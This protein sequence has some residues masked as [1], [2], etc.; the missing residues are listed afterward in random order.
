MVTTLRPYNYQ[1]DL[2]LK[3]DSGAKARRQ[4]M[5]S[6]KQRDYATFSIQECE[7]AQLPSSDQTHFRSTQNGDGLTSEE[8]TG[9]NAENIFRKQMASVSLSNASALHEELE[10]ILRHNAEWVDDQANRQ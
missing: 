5:P 1:I 6:V 4:L 10:S 9:T 2:P 3:Q 8:R 7:A